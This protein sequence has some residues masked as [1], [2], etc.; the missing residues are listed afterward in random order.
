MLAERPEWVA[1]GRLAGLPANP[2]S[3]VAA[4]AEGKRTFEEAGG[5]DAYF[6]SPAEASA[7]EG[8]LIVQTLA[9]IL[10]EAVVE[11]LER[12]GEC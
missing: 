4:I 12:E 7:E 1:A 3:L 8:R 2:R 10:E 9:A 5:S 6:G 11:A